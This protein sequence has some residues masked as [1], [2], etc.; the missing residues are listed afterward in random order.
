MPKL[1]F[2][3][4]QSRAQAASLNS[5]GE[6]ISAII[7]PQ[8][9]KASFKARNSVLLTEELRPLIGQEVFAEVEDRLVTYIRSNGQEVKEWQLTVK[10]LFVSMPTLR[11][12]AI[13]K[14]ADICDYEC[15][16]VFPKVGEIPM[17]NAP[18]E[19]PLIDAAQSKK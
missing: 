17:P 5:N 16:V 2:K 3:L 19:E 11:E 6:S 1:F 14:L 10:P 7:I 15:V 18:V 12:K 13:E 8:L 4:A 9:G